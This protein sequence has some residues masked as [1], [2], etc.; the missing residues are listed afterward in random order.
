VDPKSSDWQSRI[1][2][3]SAKSP[4]AL[5]M[6]FVN[7]HLAQGHAIAR[8]EKKLQPKTAEKALAVTSLGAFNCVSPSGV[9]HLLLSVAANQALEANKQAPY[10]AWAVAVLAEKDVSKQWE[11]IK[12]QAKAIGAEK[13]CVL[14]SASLLALKVTAVAD[15]EEK[16]A[17]YT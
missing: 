4:T 7:L 9:V 8:A 12:A 1:E 13:A 2:K 17:G 3:A 15:E 10:I 5:L 6:D 16:N 11:L 14:L